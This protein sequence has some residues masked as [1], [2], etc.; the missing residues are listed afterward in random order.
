MWESHVAGRTEATNTTRHR[1]GWRKW[2]GGFTPQLLLILGQ[3]TQGWFA[4]WPSCFPQPHITPG[5]GTLHC[6]IATL[7]KC[8]NFVVLSRV[9][10]TLCYTTRSSVILS[11]ITIFDWQIGIGRRDVTVS[12]ATLWTGVAV[13]PMHFEWTTSIKLRWEYSLLVFQ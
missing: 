8:T 5:W 6:A 3:R 10:S 2:L 11:P 1:D 7:G 12:I 9:S 4:E 13:H